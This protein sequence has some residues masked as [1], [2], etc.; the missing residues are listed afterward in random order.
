[1][2][3]PKAKQDLYEIKVKIAGKFY[4]SK[5]STLEEALS[6]LSVRNPRGVSV[7]NVTHDDKTRTKVVLPAITGRL[8]SLK[9]L[10]HEIAL[11][12]FLTL[13]Q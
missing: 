13:F 7:W 6:K 10:A 11:K 3:E 4:T 12:R 9:G 2:K 1:M 5:G 8:F